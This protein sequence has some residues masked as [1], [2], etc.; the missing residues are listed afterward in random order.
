MLYVDVE[1]EDGGLNRFR[2]DVVLVG[3]LVFPEPIFEFSKVH[4][5]PQADAPP[6]VRKSF[7]D[8][9]RL[10]RNFSATSCRGAKSSG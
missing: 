6:M 9:S 4:G 7:S 8:R 1:L 10:A 3:I 5:D 2:L